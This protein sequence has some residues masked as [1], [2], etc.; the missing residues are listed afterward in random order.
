MITFFANFGARMTDLFSLFDSSSFMPHGH[1]YH[2]LPSLL[3]LHVSADAVIAIA[4]FSIPVALGYLVRK[5]D[6]LA[7]KPVFW[8]F[9]AFILLCGMTH[10]S[11]IWTIWYPDYWQDGI[12]KG[13]TALVSMATALMLWPLMPSMLAMPSSAQLK[14]ANDSLR[15]EV[16]L[17]TSTEVQLRDANTALSQQ[18]DILQTINNQLRDEVR[19]RKS[20]RATGARK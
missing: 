19:E 12:L 11:S 6:D 1:C 9:A 17:R 5:R 20:R 10:L 4:Y 7:Y 15:N 2:W 14:R 3:A 8:L 13:A 16:A 18:A